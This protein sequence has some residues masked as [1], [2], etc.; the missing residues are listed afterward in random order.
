MALVQTTLLSLSIHSLSLNYTTSG[1]KTSPYTRSLY[2]SMG[3]KKHGML[4]ALNVFL[5][6]CFVVER[7]ST[8]GMLVSNYLPY[9]SMRKI[10]MYVNI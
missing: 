7:N 4:P 2:A 5:F 9:S 1:C 6:V 3:L 10:C 8:F